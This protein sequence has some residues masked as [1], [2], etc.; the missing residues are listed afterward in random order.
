[1]RD[2]L[3]FDDFFPGVKVIPACLGGEVD[4]TVAGLVIAYRTSHQ[5]R[6][7]HPLV[8]N[9]LHLTVAIE[10]HDERTHQGVVLEMSPAC[11]RI[12]VRHEA[13][14]ELI[15]INERL[16]GRM[17]VGRDVPDLSQR[18]LTMRAEKGNKG[19]K[20]IP[21]CLQLTPL[22]QVLILLTCTVEELLSSHIAVLD[23][24]ATLIH[25]PEGK[26]GNRIVQACRHLRTHILPAG[27]DVA[28]PRGCGIALLASKTATCQQEHPWLI[29]LAL[30]D[31]ALTIVDGIGINGA[32]GIEVFCRGAESR[33][34]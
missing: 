28:T 2:I 5:R 33:G 20:L 23:T 11:H 7:K 22:L 14:A 21:A 12:E 27:T 17:I 10:V 4:T 34:A 1:M 25:A 19:A 8:A 30:P 24:E 32:V 16:V 15:I 3:C 26:T 9:F 6:T 13:I 29:L 18:P 31:T